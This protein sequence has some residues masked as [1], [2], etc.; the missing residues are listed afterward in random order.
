VLNGT[1]SLSIVTRGLEATQSK[2]PK[3]S[4]TPLPRSKVTLDGWVDV[5]PP[6]RRA[7]AVIMLHG[8][9]G[10]PA[11]TCGYWSAAVQGNHW[12]VCPAGNASCGRSF[13]WTGGP[14]ERA[15]Y[16]EAAVDQLRN[17]Y[18][19][20]VSHARVL[21]GFSRGAFVAR[22]AVYGAP[23]HRYRGLMFIG[24][25]M[26]LDVARLKAAGIERVVM[27]S[28]DFDGARR[29]MLGNTAKLRRGGIAAR[30]VSSG[31]IYHQLPANLGDIVAK[32]LPWLEGGS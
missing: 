24:A 1:L 10:A 31:R 9:C 3:K 32:Q 4:P 5:Y 13:D 8:M 21:I 20:H 2:S 23:K 29:S 22:D 11:P 12:L 19:A 14:R 16:L 25:A 26:R 17:S 30:F 28:G 15:R 27:V 6:V 7:P 18:P